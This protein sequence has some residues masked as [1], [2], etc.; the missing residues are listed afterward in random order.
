MHPTIQS[1][2]KLAARASVPT[3]AAVCS[4]LDAA[5]FD[6]Y[7]RES[8]S[9]STLEGARVSLSQ[10]DRTTTTGRGGYFSFSDVEPGE[11]TVTID[12]LGADPVTEQVV[13]SEGAAN[14]LAAE[15]VMG[16]TELDEVVVRSQSAAQSTALNLYRNS[17]AINNV[18]SADEIG[19]FVDQNVA[20]ALQRL[21]GVSTTRDQGEGRFVSVR[22][23]EAGLNSV[24]INGMRIGTPEDGSRE[25]ALDVIP[26]GSVQRLEVVKVPTPDMPG[27]SIGGAINVSSASAFDRE[28]RSIRYRVEGSY[29]DLTGDLSPK[30]EFG[31]S[32]IVGDGKVGISFGLNYLDRDF[33]SDNIETEYDYLDVESTG[34]EALAP[35]E[36]QLRKY[37]INRERLGAN[38]NLDFRIDERNEYFFN[39]LYSEFTDAETRQRSIFVFEDGDLESIAGGAATFREIEPDGFRRRIRFRT[40]EQDTLA[41]SAGGSHRL[42]DWDFDYRVGYS[43]ASET[44]PDE[45]EGRF[46]YDGPGLDAIVRS[47]SGIPTFE[48]LAGG[49][50]DSSHLRNENSLLDRVVLE[51]KF[52]DENDLNFSANLERV[53][54]AG[55]N[56]FTLKFGID[57]R[58]KEKDVDVNESELRDVPDLALDGFSAPTDGVP[59]GDL[60]DGISSSAFLDYFYGNRGLFAERPQDVAENTELSASG[61]FVAEE[62]VLA[63][64]AMGTWDVDDWRFIAGGRVEDTDFSAVGNQIEFNEDG[65]LVGVSPRRASSSYSNFL[66]A[67]HARYEGFEDV[68]L[69]GAWSNT[70]ARPSFSNLSPGALVN[71]EDLE[72]ETG[73]PDLDPYESTN[74]DLMADWYLKGAGVISAGVFYKDI[75]NYIV[76]FTTS[77]DAEFPGFEVERPIN[78]TSAEVK[79]LELNWEQRLNQWTQSLDGFLVGANLTLLDSKFT[80]LERPGETFA[81]PLASEE[82]SNFYVGYERGPV[83]LRLSA[84]QRGKYL[85]EIGDDPN[86]DIYVA[87]HSQLDFTASWRFTEQVE[88]AFEV[89]NIG[90]EPLELYQGRK[91]NNLQFEEYG[92]TYVLGVKGRF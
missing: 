2:C 91:G 50:P 44:S 17:D 16:Y 78:G 92:L 59:F 48:I 54:D 20:E 40:Q 30:W 86:F 24:T 57:G 49:S 9:G 77:S 85:D 11:Y 5:T 88:L 8:Y 62:D 65:D 76:D 53:F 4:L 21:P 66:P 25:V 83:S 51:S 1:L 14:R 47:G 19:Q 13:V 18:I 71:R 79:G 55:D 63:A 56:P 36:S 69:R 10:L 81:L 72:V 26:S 67:L 58:F 74:F 31:Y 60:G 82:L 6:G 34:G 42:A 89:I 80:L 37:F 41:L 32:D 23:I 73:N 84:T 22:G 15:V 35:I 64:Y 75:D 52:V 43:E 12:Y 70:I 38:L 29:S 3:A 87:D 61:D 39:I 68:V 46:E 7:V 28:G 33:G 27:D 90:D 45:R